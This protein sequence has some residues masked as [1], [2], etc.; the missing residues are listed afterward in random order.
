MRLLASQLSSRT[1]T[2]AF[3]HGK[4]ASQIE[5]FADGSEVWI[6]SVRT[7]KRISIHA[8]IDKQTA[9]GGSGV[10]LIPKSTLDS[11]DGKHGDAVV[12]TSA[13]PHR[14]S[15]AAIIR[16]REP[17]EG[18][19]PA[20]D[21]Y[22]VGVPPEALPRV[23]R[24][25]N[26]DP[27]RLIVLFDNSGSMSGAPLDEAKNALR[28]LLFTKLNRPERLTLGPDEVGLIRFGGSAE[29]VFRP[30]RDFLPQLPKIMAL[31]SD[32]QTPMETA[33]NLVPAQ[34]NDPANAWQGAN[35]RAIMITD[36]GATVGRGCIES[37]MENGVQV[38]A[39][40]IGGGSPTLEALASATGGA[41]VETNN[42]W[43]LDGI[44]AALA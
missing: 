39:I 16:A 31:G 6:E 26:L 18:E 42:L 5:W 44:L 35:R 1:E 37:L 17:A 38:I 20:P 28:T 13:K 14:P 40:A 43:Q 29:I 2:K 7:G 34:Y 33:L 36:G 19:E 41:V 27:E 30:T 21:D 15:V 9:L 24:R 25:T 10:I 32:G 4:D 23:P 3:L 12:V 8:E 11:I 22:P